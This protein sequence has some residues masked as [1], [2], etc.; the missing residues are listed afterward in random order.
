MSRNLSIL[1][2]SPGTKAIPE[3]RAAPALR[4][5]IMRQKER[6]FVDEYSL[7]LAAFL[8][9]SEKTSSSD[10]LSEPAS[11]SSCDAM[12]VTVIRDSHE[13]RKTEG[14]LEFCNSNFVKFSKRMN[15]FLAKFPSR[16]F[17]G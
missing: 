5:P 3:G 14:N 9:V 10:S 11:S 1:L 4:E 16:A 8:D 6:H 15:F 12:V 17:N 7:R 13:R 2:C